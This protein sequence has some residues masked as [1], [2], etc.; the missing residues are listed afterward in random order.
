MRLS[1]RQGRG[2][3]AAATVV[4]AFVAGLALGASMNGPAPRSLA[5]HPST[6][7]AEPAPV[8]AGQEAPPSGAPSTAPSP[9][10]EFASVDASLL[11]AVTAADAPPDGVDAVFVADVVARANPAFQSVSS[12]LNRLGDDLYSGK[13]DASDAEAL[14]EVPGLKVSE[15]RPIHVDPTVLPRADAPAESP[16]G[17]SIDSATTIPNVDPDLAVARTALGIQGGDQVIAIVDTGVDTNAVGLAGKVITRVDFSPA[18]LACTDRGYLDPEGHGTHVASIAAGAVDAAAP[19]VVGVA[20]EASLIDLRVFNCNGDADTSTVLQALDWVAANSVAWNIGVVNLSLGENGGQ[21]DGLDAASVVI[22]KL[23]AAGVFV[24]V[25]SGNAGDA[26]A[27]IYSPG[28]ALFATTVGAASVGPYGAFFDFYSSQGPVAGG[29]GVDLVAAGSGIIAAKSTA[30]PWAGPTTTLAGTSMATP[31]VA[32]LAALL[33]QQDPARVPH[34]DACTTGPG[35]PLGVNVASMSNGI[36][37][38]MATSDWFAPGPDDATGRGLVVASDSLRALA[39]PTAPETSVTLAPDSPS[40]MRIPP[41]DRPVTIGVLA[42]TPIPATDS[43]PDRLAFALLDATGVTMA[44][45]LPCILEVM[46]STYCFSGPDTLPQRVWYFTS[47]PSVD[48]SWL[49]LST[50]VATDIEVIAPGLDGTITIASGVRASD[51]VLDDGGV[52]TV[53]V[54]RTVTGTAGTDFSVTTSSGLSAPTTVTLPAGPAGTSATFEVAEDASY[55]PGALETAGRVALADGGDLLLAVSVRYAAP[56]AGAPG[57]MTVGG[58]QIVV[59]DP[60]ATGL[61]LAADGTIVGDSTQGSLARTSATAGTVPGPFVVDPGSNDA[62][63]LEITQTTQSGIQALGV[64]D[65]ASKVLLLEA[66]EGAGAVALDSDGRAVTFVHNRDTD[67]NTEIGNSTIK[68]DATGPGMPRL[69][70]DGSSVAFVATGGAGTHKVYWQ[71]GTDY[72]TLPP[73]LASFLGSVSVRVGGVSA[74]KVLVE[75]LT[76]GSST[77]NARLYPVGGGPFAPVA[78]V[79]AGTSRL[80]ADGSAVGYVSSS[81]TSVSCYRTSTSTTSSFNLLS[82]APLGAMTPGPECASLTGVVERVASFPQGWQGSEVVTMHA[83]GTMDV[84]GSSSRDDVAWIANVA[85]GNLLTI[86]GIPAN[87]G[88]TNGLVDVYRGA[89]TP[90]ALVATPTPVISGA[91]QVGSPLTADPGAWGPAPVSLAYQWKRGGVAI[92]GGNGRTYVPVVA[93]AGSNLSVTVT[94]SRDGYLPVSRTSVPT[95]AVPPPPIV[96]TDIAGSPF[97]ADI[98]WMVDRGITTGYAD[99]TFR[100]TAN[101]SRQAMAAFMYR[102]AGS[103]AFTPPVTS[104]FNDVSTDSSFYT[105]VTW[106][107]DQGISTGYPDGGFHPTANVSRQAMA[108]FMYRFAGSPAFTPPVTSPFNDVATDSPFYAEV[109]WMADAGIST[110]YADGGFHP[111]ANVSRQAMAAFLHRLDGIL[112]PP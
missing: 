30:N 80:S 37:D 10:P 39:T 20:P 99:G 38:A 48:A 87:P 57:Q 72:G 54:E 70:S 58:T 24:A 33:R 11:A 9:A 81:G 36:Q 12:H 56:Q 69:S 26:P 95:A 96:L 71:G 74:D 17:L 29:T 44:P 65:D 112:T 3:V 101:V 66:A 27:T 52:A 50:T 67:A 107:A 7:A 104:P 46:D 85:T 86:T 106:M 109:T 62:Q 98:Q 63:P 40:L 75:V 73:S 83:N 100:P 111:A 90:L 49:R 47:P 32:G 45:V 59:G 61:F 92:A 41:H 68:P 14:G 105:E 1:L 77:W 6:G 76:S 55:T 4:V 97:A 42:A 94:G 5:T 60:A 23:V 93:D 53:T 31:Y 88:D 110:G 22:N 8:A 64:S 43:A 51:V 35:C 25:A 91:P 103:P 89:W 78:S 13:L 82:H 19:G 16:F 79:T 15:N 108:A 18:T 102:F 21:Q 2:R 84:L 28:T 34:G